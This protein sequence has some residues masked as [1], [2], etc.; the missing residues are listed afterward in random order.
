[1]LV[2]DGTILEQHDDIQL[3]LSE[4][5]KHDFYQHLKGRKTNLCDY[6]LYRSRRSIFSVNEKQHF[7][8]VRNRANALLFK[9]KNTPL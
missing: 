7:S 9:T 6:A 1:M 5:L 8:R 3:S 2:D 4:Q